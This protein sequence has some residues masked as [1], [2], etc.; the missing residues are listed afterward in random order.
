MKFEQI[1]APHLSLRVK[2]KNEDEKLTSENAMSIKL[3]AQRGVFDLLTKDAVR[4]VVPSQ[5]TDIKTLTDIVSTGRTL[6]AKLAAPAN[7]GSAEL[8]LVLFYGDQLEMGDIEIG[9]DDTVVSALGKE[10]L[11]DAA[12]ALWGQSIYKH[13]DK[14][15]FFLVAGDAAR[16]YLEA[17]P[18]DVPDGGDESDSESTKA[19]PPKRHFAILGNDIRFALS[20]KDKPNGQTIFL[21]SGI[22]R[23]RNRREDPGLR[24]ACGN[25]R[26]VNWT[27]A[28]ERASLAQTQIAILTQRDDSYLRKWDVFADVEGEMFLEQARKVGRISFWGKEENKDGSVVV[29]CEELS[30]EQKEAL[31]EIAEVDVVDDDGLPDYFKDPNMTFSDFALGIVAED[32]FESYLGEKKKA[33]SSINREDHSS[34]LKI[35]DFNAATGELLLKAEAIPS[36]TTLIASYAGQVAQIKRRMAAR[37]QIQTGRAANPNLGLI[38]EENGQPLPAQ[39]PPKVRALTSLVEKKLFPKNK[40]TPAQ[41][42]AIEVALNTPDIALIQGP[43]GTGKTTVIAAIIERLNQ[44]ADKR[45]GIS[46]QVLLS[47]F[48][49]DAVENMIDR[50]RL[51]GLP[52]PKFGQRSGEEANADLARF[53]IQLEE[54]CEQR[55][56]ELKEKHPAITESIDEQHIRGLCVQYINAPSSALA[57]EL[58]EAALSLPYSTLEESLREQIRNELASLKTAQGSQNPNATILA[59]IRSIRTTEAGFADDGAARAADALYEIKDILNDEEKA[60]LGNASRWREQEKT[61]PFLKELKTLKGSLLKRFTP[62]PAFRM[63]KTRDTVV[64]VIYKTLDRIRSN[65]MSVKDK[66]TAA[67]AELLHEL[68]DNPIGFQNIVKDYSF[69]FAATCQQSVNR[70]MQRMKG[71]SPDVPDQKLEYECVIVD[72]AARV[73]PH[74]LM[75]AMA[76]GKRIIL[77][78][79]HRQLPQLTDEDVVKR[80]EESSGNHTENEWLT[81]SM[82]E[83][84]FTKRLPELEKI[85]GIK[86]YVTLDKQFRMHPLLGDFINRNFYGGRHPEEKFDSPLPPTLFT[87]NLP[88]TEGKCAIWMNIPLYSGNMVREGT[89]WTRPAEAEAICEKLRE[90]ILFDDKRTDNRKERLTFGV[91]SFYKAQTDLIKKRLGHEFSDYFDEGRLRIGTVDSFQGMEFDVVFLS[92]VRTGGARNGF[93]FLTVENRLNVSMS[94]Q[95]KLLVAVGDA[96]FYDTDAARTNVPGLVDFQAL[97]RTKGGM[98]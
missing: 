46:G 69:A 72:E 92:L 88:G 22:T 45:G 59:S 18:Q 6:L 19:K 24:L 42:S 27:E 7:D 38:I 21:A 12:K 62:A 13:D 48:Q 5:T 10:S 58:L 16:T 84:L 71:I 23:I 82:F 54:W 49:H 34:T 66:K 65:G 3:S 30:E 17:Q 75:I 67:I 35:I 32:A 81:M 52:V 57:I 95:K 1:S 47:G 87:H 76:Q 2:S 97:C 63:E 36:G 25:L 15:F 20:E 31:K 50:I 85:D 40:P 11:D 43:P 14:S 53:E 33:S 51:N 77:V 41:V 9:I 86:R 29:Q 56:N 74:D 80:I 8:Q 64:D 61:P 98:L 37:N 78:G 70:M 89:S 94:R 44:E 91:I 26:F 73:A 96:R 79:D 60:L 4:T 39:P 28:G 93:G 83:Y 55:V 68:E 90:W